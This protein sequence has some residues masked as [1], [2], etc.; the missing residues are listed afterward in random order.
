MLPC[1]A[2]G[3]KWLHQRNMVSLPVF[4]CKMCLDGVLYQHT[5]NIACWFGSRISATSRHCHDMTELPFKVTLTLQTVLECIAKLTQS[6]L[7][8]SIIWP[9]IFSDC[10]LYGKRQKSETQRPA[11]TKTIWGSFTCIIKYHLSH[12]STDILNKVPP[13]FKDPITIRSFKKFT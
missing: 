10:G 4:D 2:L 8:F 9:S 13:H 7:V 11:L 6:K 12:Y 1:S 5:C 3:I